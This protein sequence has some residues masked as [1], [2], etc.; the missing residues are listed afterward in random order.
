[1]AGLWLAALPCVGL[2]RSAHALRH[3]ANNLD[4]LLGLVRMF[5]PERPAVS[6]PRHQLSDGLQ[7]RYTLQ[8]VDNTGLI[9]AGGGLVAINRAP[10]V[11]FGAAA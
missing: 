5:A 9:L 7:N 4:F 2:G 10:G 6:A 11:G 8:A 3:L 1:M